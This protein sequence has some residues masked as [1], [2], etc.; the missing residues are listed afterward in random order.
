MSDLIEK[1]YYAHTKEGRPP[2]E[3]QSLEDH[4]KGVAKKARLFA[5]AFGAGDWGY[6]AGLWNDIGKQ[7]K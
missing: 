7:L 5:E 4:L 6:L 2:V 1:S 3:W